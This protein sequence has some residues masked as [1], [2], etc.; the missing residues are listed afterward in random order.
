M[1]SKENVTQEIRKT[2]C[3]RC[4][5]VHKSADVWEAWVVKYREYKPG[6]VPHDLQ[7]F[8]NY[9][10]FNSYQYVSHAIILN[11]WKY[12]VYEWLKSRKH[13]VLSLRK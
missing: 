11:N 7:T 3:P 9:K 4:P 1:A 6:Y 13:H 8:E 2:S 12:H 5:Q 10:T